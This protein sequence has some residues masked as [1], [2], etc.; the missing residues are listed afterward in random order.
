MAQYIEYFDRIG[1]P[2]INGNYI[3]TAE[4]KGGTAAASNYIR[5]YLLDFSKPFI[6]T[7]ALNN[8]VK[9]DNLTY[10]VNA[11]DTGSAYGINFFW[12]G[13]SGR[14]ICAVGDGSR[15]NDISISYDV[16]RANYFVLEWTGTSYIA[17]VEYTD[18]SVSGNYSISRSTPIPNCKIKLG[19]QGAFTSDLARFSLTHKDGTYSYKLIERIPDPVPEFNNITDRLL[20]LYETKELIRQAIIS[21]GGF[22]SDDTPFREYAYI[23]AHL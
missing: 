12:S 3:F 19:Y 14:I 21:K 16:S 5:T 4:G 8:I 10:S 17:H 1:S 13:T 9:G 6:F 18:G 15:F 11:T 2:N 22:V 23:I 7:V 20:Y